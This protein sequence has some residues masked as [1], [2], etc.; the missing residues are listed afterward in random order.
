MTFKT[1][2]KDHPILGKIEKA[3]RAAQ[4]AHIKELGGKTHIE[5]GSD[6]TNDFTWLNNEESVVRIL[7]DNQKE[8]NEAAFEIF[9][10][11]SIIN[12]VRAE[13]KGCGA[14]P[15]DP[16][17]FTHMI[18]LFATL[19]HLQGLLYYDDEDMGAYSLDSLRMGRSDPN[20]L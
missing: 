3:A 13:M 7:L 8:V 19:L 15:Q 10:D 12:I 20:G 14:F 6:E 1:L 18:C 4:K 5:D 2:K 9:F 16:E 11:H 17:H